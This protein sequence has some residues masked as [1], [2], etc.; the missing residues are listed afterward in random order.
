MNKPSPPKFFHHFLRWFCRQDYL[1][2]IEGDME[3]R[4][5][6]N[7]KAFPVKKARR[8]YAWDTLKLLRA[9]LMKRMGGDKRLNHYGMFQHYLKSGYRSLIRD[10][11]YAIISTL[12]LAV[13]MGVCLTIAQFIFFELSY[14]RFHDDYQNT[15][16]VVL[17]EANTELQETYPDIGHAFGPTAQAVIPEVRQYVRK[18]RFNRGAIVTNP[19]NQRVFHEEINDLLFVDPSFFQVFNFPLISGNQ[20]DL[21]SNKYNVVIT[22]STA[23]KYFGTKDP[24][25]K[26]LSINGAPSPGDYTVSG[27][28]E[29]P[30]LNG[31]LQFDFLMPIANY[32]EYGWG[33]VVKKQ[34]GW[35]GFSVI[36]Y[37]TLEPMADLDMV[38]KKLNAL[39]ARHKS[40]GDDI[41]EEVILQP[42]SDIY[43]KSGDLTD[44]GFIDQ[45]GSE[46]NI[47][48]FTIVSFLILLIGWT[49]TINLATS[50]AIQRTKE[51]GIR[52]SI[53]AFRSQLLGQF[54]FESLLT[55]LFAALLAL[56]LALLFIPTLENILSKELT[57][58]LFALPKFWIA[59][60]LVVFLGSI[61]SGL[62]PA[63]V[64][65]SF[66]PISML[67]SYK[68]SS[69]G[70]PNLRK[71]LI[72]FQFIISLSLISA[73]YMVYKQTAFMKSRDLG[74]DLEQILI[75]RG[76]QVNTDTLNYYSPFFNE[77]KDHHAISAVTG[78]LMVPGQYWILSYHKLGQPQSDIPHCRGFFAGL[79]FVKTYG[80]QMV[81]GQEFTEAMVDEEAVIIN[82]AAVQAFGF[83]TPEDALDQ[84]L[85]IGRARTIV[86]VIKNFHWHSLAE[87]HK[88]YAIDL[89][90]KN[91]HPYISIRMNTSNFKETLEYVESV[92]QNHFPADPFDFFFA[93]QS[94][95]QQY[96]AENQF[97][98]LFLSFSGLAI[99]IGSVG[100]FALISYS[101][102]SKIKEIG[103]RK[104]LGATTENIVLLLSKEYF[105]LSAIA[106]IISSPAIWIMGKAWL[107][108]YAYRIPF[109]PDLFLVPGLIVILMAIL[110]VSHRTLASAKANPVESL[111]N[112]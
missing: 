32:L 54:I 99:L 14:D 100:L 91:A 66:K 48:I 23:K 10:K 86:G 33:G 46:R 71:G 31:H 110:M 70:N 68:T 101:A 42:I 74:M 12:G 8:L 21:F 88:P 39:I 41:V 25:D 81:A 61:F 5:Q 83:A 37:L 64:L 43:L 9:T 30:P 103:I 19:I 84:K 59:F 55:S 82:E 4:F 76:P 27:V 80:L 85:K 63:F 13:G 72:T 15:Y 94:F 87:D 53:G 109:S 102:N 56:G 92:Y 1:E 79:D 89:Y 58:S 40:A 20:S 17:R 108:N 34:D 50:Q 49:N 24:V 112:E 97:A 78:S 57:L 96:S 7:L 62:Y 90:E 26:T 29:D 105:L 16:R 104:V 75:L 28:L 73:T 3:E 38:S 2:E 77:L 60:V 69:N 111:R 65:S 106:I 18:E 35:K 47:R 107:A 95:N 6:D 36:T 93:D 44:A 98:K 51:V 52:K 67:R 45:V 11:T 22:E